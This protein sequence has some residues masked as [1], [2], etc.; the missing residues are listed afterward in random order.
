M[1]ASLGEE[2]RAAHAQLAPGWLAFDAP[3]R[4][5]VRAASYVRALVWAEGAQQPVELRQDGT[6]LSQLS[7]GALLHLELRADLPEDFRI[8]PLSPLEQA[9]VGDENTAWEWIVTPRR[10]GPGQA[11]HLTA[12]NLLDA[13]GRLIAKGLPAQTLTVDVSVEPVATSGR[14]ALTAPLRVFISHASEDE[15]AARELETH[16][17]S[18]RRAGRLESWTSRVTGGAV[19][20]DEITRR[21]D[22]ADVVVLILSAAYMASEECQG[23]HV[24]RAMARRNLADL[25]VIPVRWRS[26]DTT[27]ASFASLEAVPTEGNPL[28]EWRHRD[29]AW[30]GV[31]AGL[32]TQE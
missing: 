16:M 8:T 23:L 5:R 19:R 11:L 14:P 31:V 25:R 4:M 3:T 21:I 32:L 22:A 26:V 12:W 10:A 20:V 28:A 17:A 9:L 29:Q 7:L 1:G 24:A 30:C 6:V 2:L 27:G 13:G 18:Q 15:A